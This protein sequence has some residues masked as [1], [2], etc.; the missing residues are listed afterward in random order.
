MNFKELSEKILQFVGGK[1]N[2]ISVV[3]CATR[4]RFKLKDSKKTNTGEMKALEGVITVVESGGQYQ[5]VIGNNVSYVYDEIIKNGEISSEDSS[6]GDEKRNETL[7]SRFIDLISGIFSPLIS[8]MAA[9]GILKGMLSL[10]T[11][12]GWLNSESGTYKILY[13][14]GDALFYFL[15]IM[16]G[17]TA[18]KK[19]NGNPFTCMAIGGALT[20]PVMIA[21]FTAGQLPDTS[22][23]TFLGIPVIL[24]NYSSSVIP[25]LF[26]AWVSCHLEHKVSGWLPDMIR[27]FFTPLICLVVTVTLTFLLIGPVATWASRL[28]ANGFQWVY[29]FSPIVAGAIMGAFWQIFVIFGLHWGFVPI[30]MNN[31]SMQGHDVL[32]PLLLPAVIGQTGATLG[33]LLRTRDA[34]LKGIAGSACSAAIFGISEPAIY[35]VTLPYRRPFIIGC[36]SGAIGSA[37]LGYFHTTIFSMGLVSIFTLTQIIP[38]TGIDASVWGAFIGTATAFVL[39]VVLTFLFGLPKAKT[40][41]AQLSLPESRPAQET[42]IHK[43]IIT[44][45]AGGEVVPLESVAD[46]TFA[47]GLLG[48]GIALIPREGRIV[49]PVDG[50]V[51]SLFKTGHA[52]GLKSDQG[53][54]ILIHIGIDT[55]KLNGQFF[56]ACRQAGE[57]VKAGDVLIEFSLPDIIAAGYDTT[58]LIIITNSDAYMDVLPCNN[59]AWVNEM[60]PLLALIHQAPEEK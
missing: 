58:T 39:A 57:R 23:I 38:P 10:L 55:V 48:K 32:M 51:A 59:D 9:T 12:L 8:V 53:S 2:I 42:L 3:H 25:I 40:V 35:G 20:H 47:S 6:A 31:I 50:T 4:L 56:T 26:A 60:S 30:I 28:L 19:F 13:A 7:F 22:P 16:L 54:E 11:A 33:V 5:V 17:Y 52:I 45:P 1:A 44:S 43:E 14:A 41:P 24:I 18:A 34:K 37:I 21:A 49:A 46:E 29:T 15:P 27:N 36:L